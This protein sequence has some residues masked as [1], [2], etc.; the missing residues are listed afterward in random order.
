MEAILSFCSGLKQP[1]FI[2]YLPKKGL[3][4]IRIDVSWKFF[5][6]IKQTAARKVILSRYHRWDVSV[7]L[8]EAD[9]LHE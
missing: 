7:A 2:K 3:F 8:I 9:L 5:S 4:S 1:I 6:V